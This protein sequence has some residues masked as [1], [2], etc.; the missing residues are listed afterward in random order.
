METVHKLKDNAYKLIFDEPL[1]F[2]EFLKNFIPIDVLKNANPTDIEDITER[3]LPLFS[4]NKDS[5]TVK[6]IIIDNN[7]PLFV[8]CILEHESE[9]NYTSSFKM[10]QYIT[11]VLSDYV[12]EN[13]KRYDT[14]KKQ[15]YTSLKR[16]NSKDFKLP[17]VLPIVFYDGATK[18]TSST[19]FLDRTE[20]NDVF[21]KYIPKFEYE[22]VD[23]NKYSREDLVNYG[24][25]LSL[26]MLTDKVRTPEEWEAFRTL[27]TDYWEKL[28]LNVP[29]PLLKLIADCVT[30]MLLKAEVRKEQIET[31]TE[32]IYQRRFSDMFDVQFSFKKIREEA[33]EK[34]RKEGMER[35]LEAA[36]NF[37][38]LGVPLKD[39]AESTGLSEDVILKFNNKQK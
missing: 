34:G 29:E 36:K 3:F 11:Y 26:I 8:I 37:L 31:V 6:K 35:L 10:L 1:L 15:G 25:A 13:D 23:L 19:N 22:L 32:K 21:H 24:N 18:W 14:E 27:S 16:S 33:E 2:V 12:K 28:S 4:D 17:P 5:D 39:V 30:M 7:E 9:V 20:L 38:Q